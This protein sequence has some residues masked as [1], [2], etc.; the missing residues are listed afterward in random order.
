MT[1]KKTTIVSVL[2]FVAVF[3]ALLITAT[4]TDLQVSNILTSK[5]LAE[6]TYITNDAFGAMFEAVGSVPVY[7]MF[8]FGFE[9]LFWAVVRKNKDGKVLSHLIAIG[10]AIA[11]VVANYILVSD[12]FN[13]IL[14]H[15]YLTDDSGAFTTGGYLVG[16][17]VFVSI[18]FAFFELLAVNNFSD[19]SINKL[20][21]FAFATI[22]AAA[23]ATITIE[24]IKKPMGRIRYRAMNIDPDNEIHGF[25]AFARWFE[26]NGAKWKELYPTHEA[27]LAEFGSTD[28]FKSFPSGHTNA[29]GGTY[30]LI[31]LIPAL[32]IQKKWK[33]ALLWICPVIFTGIV[34]VSRIVVGAHFFSDVLVGGTNAFVWM[35]IMREIFICKGEHIKAVFGKS[36]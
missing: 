36:N 25:G 5:A 27:K 17:E 9:I 32:G 11:S 20:V 18:L 8:A 31:M 12:M 24:L 7:F 34:A 10:L 22:A 3:A 13:Y 16:I 26:V 6:H 33:K 23:V 2:L 19:E 35:I 30:Y 1:K 15:I 4:F 14:K 21:R 29:A 28:A